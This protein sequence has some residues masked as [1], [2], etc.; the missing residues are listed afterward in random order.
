MELTI[1]KNT[2]VPKGTPITPYAMMPK[3]FCCIEGS[4]SRVFVNRKLIK[5]FIHSENGIKKMHRLFLNEEA[6][7]IKIF[8]KLTKDKPILLRTKV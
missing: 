1:I 4:G 2:G 8:K 7:I 5:K 3:I 6:R